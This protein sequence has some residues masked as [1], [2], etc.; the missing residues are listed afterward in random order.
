MM[1]KLII[2]VVIL[3]IIGACVG[4]FVAP[5][6]VAFVFDGS[7]LASI[8]VFNVFLIAIVVHAGAIMTGYPLAA[9]V[10]RLDVANASVMTGA[11]V[12]FIL[13]AIAFFSNSVTPIIL[14]FIMMTSEL[15]VLLHRSIVLIPIAL[16]NSQQNPQRGN[17][18]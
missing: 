13:L 5:A 7:W 12:Y 2:G 3:A 10:G 9:L 16:K 6:L 1:F 8:P 11:V 14:A 17:I 4:Y 15:A 18:K